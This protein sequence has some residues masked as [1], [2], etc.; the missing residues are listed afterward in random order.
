[1]KTYKQTPS[2]PKWWG[3]AKVMERLLN[4]R[5]Q[6]TSDKETFRACGV[7]AGHGTGHQGILAWGRGDF[8]PTNATPEETELAKQF[9]RLWRLA[10]ERAPG[11]QLGYA[12]KAVPTAKVK[13]ARLALS[14]IEKQWD[15]DADRPF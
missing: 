3:N 6:Y 10:R 9:T 4:A 2:I 7:G 8:L 13:A 5:P 1:M 15:P 14:A 11:G 12:R